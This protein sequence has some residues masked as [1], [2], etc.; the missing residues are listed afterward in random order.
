MCDKL[1]V[2]EIQTLNL[3]TKVLSSLPT[4]ISIKSDELILLDRVQISNQTKFDTVMSVY[5]KRATIVRLK[6]LKSHKERLKL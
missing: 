6:T 1:A 5:N 3:L 4:Q 2:K